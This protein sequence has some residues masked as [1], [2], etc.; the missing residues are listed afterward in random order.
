MINVYYHHF[1][2]APSL[3]KMKELVALL[4]ER[5]H[6][7][8]FKFYKD[9]DKY[10][11]LVG[12]LM[13]RQFLLDYQYPVTKLNALETDYYGKPSIVGLP[14]FNISHTHGMIVCA[15]G[16]PK[17]T[18]LG[19]D[20]E[21]VKE[22]ELTAFESCFNKNEWKAIQYS[23]DTLRT[24]YRYWTIKES[25]IKADG[26]GLSL[27]PIRVMTAGLKGWELGKDTKWNFHSL[28]L[29]PDYETHVCLSDEAT[30]IKVQQFDVALF[31]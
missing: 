4:P 27:E 15:W 14:K 22:I 26:R 2:Q 17:T 18:V 9:E 11:A 21:L 10:K 23:D 16:S 20:V 1:E 29:H 13:L 25:F 28:N 31:A 30:K 19:I 6:Q 8:I 7:D 3:I 24:F 12:K 5:F